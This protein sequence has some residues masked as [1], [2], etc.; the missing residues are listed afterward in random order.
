M[1]LLKK[2][3]LAGIVLV[4]GMSVAACVIVS[5]RIDVQRIDPLKDIEVKTPV[6]AHLRDGTTVVYPDGVKIS[7]GM[8]HGQ[9]VMADIALTQQKVV[10]A[11][12]LEDV[13]GMESYRTGVNKTES[14]LV[15]A[16]ATAGAVVGGALLAVAIFGSCPTVYSDDGNVEEAELFSSSIAP[17]FE[18]RDL[19]RLKAQPDT[20]GTLRLEV[21]NEAME[22]HYINHLQ[23]LE[24]VHAAD[25]FVLPDIQDGIVAVRNIHVP[26]DITD[27]RGQSVRASVAD[28]DEKAYATD[29]RTVDGASAA[30]MDDWLEFTTPVNGEAKSITFVFRLRNSLLGTTLMYDVMLGPSGAR[31]L[32]WM[33][34]DL[35]NI[36]TAVELGRWFEKRAGLHIEVFRNG[37][38]QEVARVPDTG[39]ISWHDIAASIPV[40][41]GEDSLRIRL[42]F[43]A[44]HWRIDRI[45]VADAARAVQPRAI[46]ISGVAENT[47]R[48]APDAQRYLN[49]PDDHYLQTNPGQRI[50]VQFDTGSTP[51]NQ[52]RT[53][54]LSSQGYYIEWIRGKWLETST[55]TQPFV[56][57]DES[58][59]TSLRL[60]SNKRDTFEKQFR[61]ARV[62]VR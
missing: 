42:S 14:I 58:L 53:F 41:P 13:A 51:P 12:P 52:S 29:S 7:G 35:N 22:T 21:R 48:N 24:A 10:Q 15:S 36:S 11:I 62:P 45:G 50:F 47:G 26:G 5:H 43:L 54:L 30:D 33:N 25:E 18:A 31:A 34:R 61:E 16:A 8:I 9:G 6:K 57:S 56:P 39:P 23:I 27:R 44:D 28:V 55:A 38:F 32:D 46:P 3:L 37:E 20:D 49:Q 19:D 4:I 1:N 17:L 60:W 2:Y 40:L 59:L